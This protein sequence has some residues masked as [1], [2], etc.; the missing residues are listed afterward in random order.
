MNVLDWIDD[1]RD[2]V[3][4]RLSR[5]RAGTP[6]PVS[7]R[8]RRKATATALAVSG[9]DRVWWIVIDSAAAMAML[10]LVTV[11]WLP[12][13]GNGWVW[14][15]SLGSG[16]IGAAIAIVT[17]LRRWDALRTGAL[18]VIAYLLSGTFLAMPSAGLYLAVPTLRSLVGLIQGPVFGWKA[19]LTL[20]PPIGETGT[21]VPVRS[22]ESRSAT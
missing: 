22:L 19:M 14:V 4:E 5:L 2:Q 18:T 15:A 1:R 11:A 17:A 3:A 7:Q 6:V 20:Q 10:L 12:A 16:A 9:S 21:G 13:Y 8:R